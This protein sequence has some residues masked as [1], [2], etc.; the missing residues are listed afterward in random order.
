MC[1]RGLEHATCL[2]QPKKRVCRCRCRCEHVHA[3]CTHALLA[4]G[5]LLILL[6]CAGV[7]DRASVVCRVEY[8]KSKSAGGR[9]TACRPRFHL[10]AL[11]DA[12]P[13]EKLSLGCARMRAHAC[14]IPHQQ[15]A[16]A[17][18]PDGEAAGW[19]EI[20]VASE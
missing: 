6:S 16:L 9:S 1:V 8:K 2:R 4:G 18:R 10:N 19:W 15:S 14:G 7:K 20:S 12:R 13:N 11:C 5:E 17:T 3:H